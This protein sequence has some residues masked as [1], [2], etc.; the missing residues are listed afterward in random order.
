MTNLHYLYHVKNE[1]LFVH[2]TNSM[3]GIYIKM[4]NNA[5]MEKKWQKTK[6]WYFHFSV[7]VRSWLCK[8]LGIL[9][10]VKIKPIKIC[11]LEYKTYII[12]RHILYIWKMASNRL[13]DRILLSHNCYIRAIKT[14]LITV[15]LLEKINDQLHK[16][17]F[18]GSFLTIA[19]L[20][21]GSRY[22]FI[23]SIT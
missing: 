3:A 21:K 8:A 9:N 17:C 20:Q 6:V 1:F 10:K 4:Y 7:K 14:D 13:L 5:S 19:E 2:N 15:D 16:Q 18:L 11:N 23:L 22:H 12:I